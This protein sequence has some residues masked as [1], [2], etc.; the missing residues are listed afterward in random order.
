[1]LGLVSC[2]NTV[3]QAAGTAS[4]P[5]YSLDTKSRIITIH[6]KGDAATQINNALS[7]LAARPDKNLPWTVKFDGGSYYLSK[8]LFAEKLENVSLVS[9]RGNPA[10]LVKGPDFSGEYLFYTR[11]STNVTMRG[12]DFYGQTKHYN[13]SNY[14]TD[15]NT[16]VWRDQ[17]LYFGSSNGVTVNMS[18][19][20][21]F[22]NA[23]IRVT[24]T[25]KDPIPGVNSFN[26]QITQNYFNNVFQ[27]STTSNDTI[28][29]GSSNFLFQGNTFD[30]LR[31]SVKF[32]TRT[33][34]ASS[35]YIR[36]N[37]IRSSSMDGLEIV[38]YTNVEVSNNQFQNIARNAV[39]CY[40]NERAA[41]GFAWGDGLTFK[42][43]TIN[44][45]GGG[46][47][48]SADAFP[49]GFQPTPSNVTISNNTISNLNGNAPA[50]TLLKGPFSGLKVTNNQF[51]N[52][53]SKKYIYLQQ[54]GESTE[55]SGNKAENILL[56]ATN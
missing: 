19:F 49:D 46:I 3:A 41:K 2:L 52:I 54:H 45:T 21:N 1:M 47:R 26:T 31:G 32:A 16:P 17:G 14:G 25:E 39:N 42:N 43:N 33:P 13:P 51:S 24:T 27:I 22:G 15:P 18:R 20:F 35:V 53:P 29:G 30:Y 11:F 8:S 28:H 9:D 4:P 56:S 44:N 55:I 50:I 36:Y 10:I 23:A 37:S 6:R 48:F 5:T 38:G 7:Y 34:G 12:F 40:S